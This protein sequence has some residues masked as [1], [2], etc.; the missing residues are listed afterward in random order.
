MNE[1]VGGVSQMLRRLI[2]EQIR[3]VTMLDRLPAVVMADPGQLEQ[4]LVN[5][6]I[7][8]RDAMPG[9]GALEIGVKRV[10]EAAE[11]GRGGAVTGPAVLVTVVDTGVGMD[12][13]TLSHA[14]EPFF[15][16]K[17]TGAGT[18]LGLSTVYGIVRQSSGEIWAESTVGRGTTISVLLRRVD[19][20]AEP[21][22]GPSQAP[23]EEAGTATILVVED[24]S[25]VRAFV[26]STLEHAGYRILVAGSPAQA[27]ALTEGLDERI[28]LLLT[29]LI[30]PETNGQVLAERLL[31]RRPSLRV[32]L[33]SGYAAG[34]GG[35]AIDGSHRFIEKPFGRNELTAIVAQVLAE[36]QTS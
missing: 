27:V 14:F 29:D 15:T 12:S 3:L 34:I 32:V 18:G 5:L 13:Q 30:M 24:D 2:G 26:V 1:V 28:D 8:A 4:V 7:N 25:A 11:L 6:A 9:G 35:V 33:M 16:T 21:L 17:Q 19:V 20:K 31:A 10:D 36:P 22:P 23:M